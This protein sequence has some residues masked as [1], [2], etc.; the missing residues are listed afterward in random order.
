MR[1]FGSIALH[2]LL[3]VLTAA[4]PIVP[5]GEDR[6]SGRQPVH[7]VSEVAFPQ[8]NLKCDMKKGIEV[9]R[10]A[11]EDRLFRSSAVD[12]A[13][14]EIAQRMVDKDLAALFTNCLP[15]TLDTTV[16]ATVDE[17]GK[18]DTF[19]ITGD[20]DAMWLRDS[21]NQV[22][23][24]LRFAN[25]DPS[26]KSM[27][28]GVLRRQVKSVLVDP[29]AN[30]FMRHQETGPWMSDDSTSPGFLGTRKKEMKAQLH[31]RKYEL[32][33][34][35]AVMR[36]SDGYYSTTNDTSVFDSD[37][38]KAMKSAI[39]VI[40]DMQSGTDESPVHYTFSRV[41]AR[42]SD[43]LLLGVGNPAQRC[44]LSRSPFRPSDDATMYQFLIPSNAM[45]VVYLRKIASIL[46]TVLRD[47]ATAADAEALAQEIDSALKNQVASHLSYG[48]IYPYE[49]DGF[50]SY[51]FADDANIPSLLSLPY[52]GY[53]S[54]D[55]PT[56]QRTRKFVLS[57]NNP[58]FSE[59]L[60]GKGVG[61][62]HIGRGWIWPMAIIMQALT[63]SD[64]AEIA[65]C[66]E[67]LKQSSAGTGFLHESFWKDDAGRFTRAWFAWTNTLF[68]EL[69]L[70][71]A[72]ERPYL[73]F[74][75]A[76]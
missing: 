35:C 62:P 6:Q 21:T 32:D 43:T 36:L 10:P 68:G 25:S 53:T 63:S 57:N 2:F 27:L 46:R 20:I 9:L 34:L 11:P 33:S 40:R 74:G 39:K 44:G 45:A 22:W 17:S 13:I 3:I 59:G 49:V 26:L 56:Y 37:W 51:Y 67:T 76:Q 61:G 1:L 16:T 12:N 41:T 47:S 24:Y 30:A 55:D 31:E 58:W 19:V 14:E 71:V 65:W 75:S 54:R 66:L 5:T 64:D 72:E 29:Y 69:I 60:A 70:K 4:K 28:A 38:Q 42:P 52:L 73:I 23:P 7:V 48:S 18:P 8:D 50:G 15:N